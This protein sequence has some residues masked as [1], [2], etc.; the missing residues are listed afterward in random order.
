MNHSEVDPLVKD[1]HFEVL[2]RAIE[3]EVSPFE[4][5]HRRGRSAVSVVV[6][7]LDLEEGEGGLVSGR[8][9]KFAAE[10]LSLLGVVPELWVKGHL[11]ART[12][13]SS[14]SHMG[15]VVFECVHMMDSLSCE[16]V[17]FLGLLGVVT[18]DSTIKFTKFDFGFSAHAFNGLVC[19]LDRSQG[20]CHNK[21]DFSHLI[22]ID[23]IS[24][25]TRGFGG[26]A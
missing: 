7:I 16:T 15:V 18:L 19:C 23:P 3:L 5:D 25:A 17:A 4:I 21:K 24:S 12:G 6:G 13:P 1:I 2:A 14:I 8:Y 26:G 11:R 9:H 20:H 22:I 10:F